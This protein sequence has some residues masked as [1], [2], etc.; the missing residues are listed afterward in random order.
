MPRVQGN[1]D[2]RFKN[3]KKLLQQYIDSGG[4]A[5]TKRTRPWDE[6]TITNVWSTSKTVASL[7]ALMLI[8]RG[9]LEPNEKVSKY[10]PE[11]AANRK[12]NIEVRHILLH[13][14]GVSGWEKDGTLE[15]S[16]DVPKATALLAE[17]APFW[18]PGTASGY[19]SLALGHLI[20]ALTQRATGKSLKQ[21]IAEEIAGPL[22]ADFQLGA[23]EKDWPRVAEIIPPPSRGPPAAMDPSSVPI[24]SMANPLVKA[25]IAG[26]EGWRRAEVGAANGHGNARSIARMLSAVSLG[27]EVDGK[28]LLSPETIGMIFQEQARGTDLV[29]GENLNHGIGHGLNTRGTDLAQLP[30]GKICLWRGWGGSMVIMDVERKVTVAYVMNKIE[31]VGL[32][33]ARTKVYIKA[34]YDALNAM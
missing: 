24:R 13:T 28:R 3:A 30:E 21:F 9:I 16:Y 33:N 4:Y 2:D 23:A 10:W 6:N 31:K 29:V 22:D 20:S 17:Q 34:A 8:S 15:D 32:G 19:H 7:A 11:F 27:G 25:E 1:C 12:E 5:N 26:N 18:T 14:S